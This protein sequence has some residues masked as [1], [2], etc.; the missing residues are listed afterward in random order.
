MYAVIELNKNQYVVKK[1]EEIIVDKL[2]QD[3]KNIKIETVLLYKDDNTTLIGK[4]YIKN[5]FV[6]AEIID[7]FKDKKVV[8]F[9]YKRKKNYKKRTGHRQK[10]TILKINNIAINP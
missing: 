10:Y 7:E 9:K 1:D 2:V 8:V 5:A 6:D 3:N 4:P